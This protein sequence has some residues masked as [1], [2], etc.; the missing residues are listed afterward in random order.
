MEKTKNK[1]KKMHNNSDID[2]LRVGDLVSFIKF[3]EMLYRGKVD[4]LHVFWGRD[5]NDKECIRELWFEEK[6]LIPYRG[7]MGH[8]LGFI[9]DTYYNITEN[10]K[11]L[12]NKRDESLKEVGL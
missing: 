5:K 10:K 4:R 3:G 8:K 2:N 1:L 9:E 6:Q 11:P 7:E 12:Y